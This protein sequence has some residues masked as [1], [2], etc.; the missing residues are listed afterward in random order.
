[1]LT[2]LL[3][4]NIITF[5]LGEMLDHAGVT[6]SNTQ[7]QINIVLNCFCLITSVT[8]S[9]LAERLGRRFLAISSTASLTLFIF[10]IGGLTKLYGQS[11]DIS[12]IYGTVASIFLFQGCYGFGWTPLTVMYPPE[13]LSYPLRA[14]GMGLFTFVGSGVGL[15]LPFSQPS[16][17]A[18]L[19]LNYSLMVVFAFPIALA[20]IG[21]K[22]YMINGAWD[23]FEL[24][25][26][27]FYWIETKGKSLE[28]IDEMIEGVRYNDMP[29][30]E[31]IRRDD[32]KGVDILIREEVV[33]QPPHISSK[34]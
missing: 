24:L 28:E 4:N 26:V 16:V 34:K 3:G 30:L 11:T 19:I 33:S 12:G 17:S 13:V 2:Q 1:V 32:L 31:D 15:V 9:L 6:N 18:S 29:D 21:W 8:G 23:V 22:I 7:L 20:K 27:N 5:Y 14:H 10:I 25:F